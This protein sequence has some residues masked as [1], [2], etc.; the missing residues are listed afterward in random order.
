MTVFSPPELN[1]IFRMSA[2]AADLSDRLH[3]LMVADDDGTGAAEPVTPEPTLHDTSN[4]PWAPSRPVHWHHA[5]AI[6]DLS[7][8]WGPQFEEAV[9]TMMRSGVVPDGVV[10]VKTTTEGN[11][12]ALFTFGEWRLRCV[13]SGMQV[14]WYVFDPVAADCYSTAL[15]NLRAICQPTQR[16]EELYEHMKPMFDYFLPMCELFHPF[17]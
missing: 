12:S 7:Q 16:Q 11:P 8:P 3:H 10:H 17:E 5:H 1:V 6:P 9:N 2:T 14:G 4:A 13:V 15:Y